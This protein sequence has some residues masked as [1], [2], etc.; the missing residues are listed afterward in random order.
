LTA[1]VFEYVWP[2]S[3]KLS[4]FMRDSELFN[5]LPEGAILPV[6]M[7]G[8]QLAGA[9]KVRA[10]RLNFNLA[11][12][13]TVCEMVLADATANGEKTA[14]VAV[15]C[16]LTHA[17]WNM[18]VCQLAGG[19]EPPHVAAQAACLPTAVLAAACTVAKVENAEEP[20]ADASAVAELRQFLRRPLPSAE[21]RDSADD[22]VLLRLSALANIT[23]HARARRRKSAVRTFLAALQLGLASVCR[24][25]AIALPASPARWDEPCGGFANAAEATAALVDFA[26]V[27]LAA[28]DSCDEPR[29]HPFA[30]DAVL[31]ILLSEV[32]LDCSRVRLA[33]LAQLLLHC[34]LRSVDS[35][36]RFGVAVTLVAACVHG[37]AR[38]GGGDMA[39]GASF[40]PLAAAA[41][42]LH[43]TAS[44]LPCGDETKASLSE[45][46][47]CRPS[48]A[49]AGG[50]SGPSL[51]LERILNPVFGGGDAETDTVSRVAGRVTRFLE[52]CAMH[53]ECGA[54]T[55]ALLQS[56]L[57]TA[58]STVCGRGVDEPS[59]RTPCFPR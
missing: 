32:F 30:E 44:R 50:A 58:L 22:D 47:S 57:Q 5:M 51:T 10:L 45:A 12:H 16:L 11:R 46:C 55:Q 41:A 9:S 43:A 6:G 25:I 23:A 38:R 14:S 2:L 48:G 20:A 34:D 28:F 21:L 35:D 17:A 52:A 31:E 33:A 19:D 49:G 8:E 18:A 56:S 7:S 27:M 24:H 36:D 26:S 39:D 3:K 15:A 53:A 13:G 59:S 37:A 1:V 42:A 29:Q 40:S 4:L 54:A